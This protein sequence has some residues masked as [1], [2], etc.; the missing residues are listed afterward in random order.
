R[1]LAP[2]SASPTAAAA[3]AGWSST[4]PTWTPSTACSSAC[5]R[6]PADRPRLP[7]R[8]R[9]GRECDDLRSATPTDRNH[10]TRFLSA[11]LLA[12]LLS[13][14]AA[15]A[16]TD[17]ADAAFQSIYEKEWAWRQADSGRGGS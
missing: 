4:T 16:Q 1:A 8:A 9:A 6:A 14:P 15:W 3:R 10:V 13:A 11:C 2:R 5:A 17:D 7:G 12:L